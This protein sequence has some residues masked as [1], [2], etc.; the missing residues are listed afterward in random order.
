M[1]TEKELNITVKTDLAATRAGNQKAFLNI[2]HMTS[3]F[4]FIKQAMEQKQLEI[5]WISTIANVADMMTT[6]KVM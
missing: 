1:P 4:H 6:E 5:D 3:R 2:K